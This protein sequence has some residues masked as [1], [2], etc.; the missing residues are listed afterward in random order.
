MA[1]SRAITSGSVVTMKAYGGFALFE[2]CER[3][4]YSSD[5]GFGL[6]GWGARQRD[7]GVAT[8][9]A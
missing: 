8:R 1:N 9:I 5:M 4:F 3:N 7:F 2:K 6:Q